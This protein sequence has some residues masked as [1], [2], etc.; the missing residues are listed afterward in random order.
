MC[1]FTRS[2]ILRMKIR[3]HARS[4][5]LTSFCVASRVA[6]SETSDERPLSTSGRRTRP[7]CNE[8]GRRLRR[9]RRFSSMFCSFCV[10]SVRE[11]VDSARFCSSSLD[12]EEMRVRGCFIISVGTR[13]AGRR[14]VRW[15]Y[16]SAYLP[17]DPV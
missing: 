8:V 9:R 3:A 11:C 1:L 4:F 7:M 17:A 2:H 13:T 15:T 12:E 10:R 16:G 14:P 5:Y 6:S